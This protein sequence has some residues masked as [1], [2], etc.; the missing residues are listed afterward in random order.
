MS[1]LKNKNIIL[2][3]AAGGVG[4]VTAKFFLES[5]AIV[6]LLDIDE[7]KLTALCKELHLYEGSMYEYVCDLTNSEQLTNTFKKIGRS[8]PIDVLVNCAGVSDV[9][10]VETA[11]EKNFDRIW[12]INVKGLYR[13]CQETIP[14][15]KK[16]KHGGSII[17]ICGITKFCVRRF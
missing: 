6:H 3:G 1:S 7:I 13:C 10:T 5:G 4:S 12:N 2:T 17:N 9:D 15:M 14:F 16:N 11:D 8:F